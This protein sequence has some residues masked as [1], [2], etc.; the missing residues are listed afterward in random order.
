MHTLGK[1]R[2]EQGA[3][4]AGAATG[5]SGGRSHRSAHLK[6][7]PIGVENGGQI[8]PGVAVQRRLDVQVLEAELH[9]RL[10]HAH[11]VDSKRR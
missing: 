1:R 6:D 10:L 9:R 8:A 3:W 4:R 7:V 11:S 2:P 5:T